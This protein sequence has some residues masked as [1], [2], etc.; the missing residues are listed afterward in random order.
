MD[1]VLFL[2][3]YLQNGKIRDHSRFKNAYL[4]ELIELLN[5]EEA[6][7][8]IEAIE[9]LTELLD[10]VDRHYIERDFIP[11]VLNTVTVGF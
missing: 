7:I 8:R 5:D 6:F 4:P 2:K 11:V 10:F 9:I 1:G 3:E